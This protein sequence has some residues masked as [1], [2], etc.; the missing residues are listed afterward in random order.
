[1]KNKKFISVIWWYHKQIFSFDKDQN[2]H[3]NPLQIMKDEGY[4]CEIFAID[5]QVKIEDDPNFI[6]WVNI[7]YYKNIFSYIWY[8]FKNR[9]NII[10]SNSLTIKTLLVWLIWKKTFFMAHDQV[11]PLL[12]KKLKRSIVLFF[13]KFFFLE[14]KSY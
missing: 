8:L 9:N 13:Y 14:R 12:E 3:M 2:Y 1:M 4:K 11:L 7:I 10:Y 5:S 6:E